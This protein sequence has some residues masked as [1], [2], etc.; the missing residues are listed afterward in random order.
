MTT[1]VLVHGAWHGGWQWREVVPLIRA[2][3]HEVTTPTLTGLGERRHLAG[4]H[5]DLSTHVADLVNHV[6]M[7][8]LERFVLVG[9]SYGGMVTT[10]AFP[11][12]RERVQSMVY[13]DAFVPERG[14]A[15]ADYAPHPI[16]PG[17]DMPP[18]TLEDFGV[19]DPDIAAFVNPRLVPQPWRTL[20][21]PSQAF[22][23][24][25]RDIPHSYLWC[26]GFS[27]SPF[28]TFYE[29][30]RD[31]P[32]FDVQTFDTGHQCMLTMPRETADFILAARVV[33]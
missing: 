33:D 25:P 11:Q 12:L 16:E 4:D 2:A 29:Q 31:D 24:R 32:Q 30:F 23:E 19:H 1:Y 15:L 9:W 13:L 3:G 5:V 18:I 7:E 8:G 17:Q 6:T 22:A 27:P 26:R 14:K 21:E 28:A 10:S 20:V